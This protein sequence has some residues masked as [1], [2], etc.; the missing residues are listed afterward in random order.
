MQPAYTDLAP[1]RSDR[2]AIVFQEL[3]TV[4]VRV[5][6]NRQPIQQVDHFRNQV[7]EALLAAQEEAVRVGYTRDQAF[8]S[9]QASAAFLDESVLN[10]PNPAYQAW[11]GHPLG[12]EFFQQHVA[13]EVFF[14]NI[15]DL[16][17]G[18]ESQQNADLLEVYLQCLLLGYRGRF[19]GREGDVR[20]ITDRISEKI[21]RIRGGSPWIVPQWMPNGEAAPRESSVWNRRLRWIA[22]GSAVLVVLSV[23]V[24]FLLL[25]SS[26]GSIAAVHVAGAIG[27]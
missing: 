11:A 17:S 20:A 1:L 22:A 4:I 18:E 23:A 26:L 10:S 6:A 25:R 13:G 24:Y 3:L 16:L 8:R 12:P 21:T 9:A 7:R 27:C 14:L 19:G 2:L 15:R 5:R